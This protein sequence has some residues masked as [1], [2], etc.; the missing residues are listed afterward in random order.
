MKLYIPAGA[1]ELPENPQI[2]YLIFDKRGTVRE[3]ETDYIRVVFEDLPA[4]PQGEPGKDGKDGA[5]GAAGRDGATGRDGTSVSAIQAASD[6][7]ALTLSTA[8]PN[9]IYFVV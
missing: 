8:N 7:E 4:G 2:P 6:S 5:P 9:N 1:A 3:L